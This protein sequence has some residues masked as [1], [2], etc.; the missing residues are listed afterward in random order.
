M[1]EKI[2]SLAGIGHFFN[3]SSSRMFFHRKTKS[4]VNFFVALLFLFSVTSTN[5]SSAATPEELK[6]IDQIAESIT[7]LKTEKNWLELIQQATQAI[8]QFPTVPGFFL[9]R[10]GAYKELKQFEPALADYRRVRQ[11]LPNNPLS[12]LGIAQIFLAQQQPALAEEAL[13]EGLRIAP[14]FSN[15]LHLSTLA[16]LQLGRKDLAEQRFSELKRV[17]PQLAEAVAGGLRELGLGSAAPTELISTSTYAMSL[18]QAL[19]DLR[20]GNVD[21]ARKLLGELYAVDRKILFQ[22]GGLGLD[23]DVVSAL[24]VAEVLQLNL[25][26]ATT[27]YGNF[28]LYSR[29]DDFAYS[30]YE[31]YLKT[32]GSSDSLTVRALSAAVIAHTSFGRMPLA[33]ERATQ[34]LAVAGV[35]IKPTDTALMQLALS[36]LYSQIGKKKDAQLASLK[37]QDLLKNNGDQSDDLNLVALVFLQNALF[38][39]SEFKE[40]DK[41]SEEVVIKLQQLKRT[42]TMFAVAQ[43]I[44][45]AQI[46]VSLRRGDESNKWNATAFTWLKSSENLK[47][48]PQSR[49]LAS[50]LTRMSWISQAFGN[51]AIAAEQQILAR[52][53]LNENLGS[54][55]TFTIDSEVTLVPILIKA[56]RNDEALLLSRKVIPKL[57]ALRSSL[58]LAEEDRMSVFGRVARAYRDSAFLELDGDP[59]GSFRASEQS[60]ARALLESNMVR[61][62]LTSGL[63]E[64]ADSDKLESLGRNLLALDQQV[65]S[66]RLVGGSTADFELKRQQITNEKKLLQKSFLVKYPKY[67]Q[68]TEVQISSP[69]DVA[70]QIQNNEVFISYL[71]TADNLLI[72]L[73]NKVGFRVSK[74]PVRAGMIKDLVASART[75]Y[76]GQAPAGDPAI[77]KGKQAAEQLSKL[78]FDPIK[79]EL[80]VATGLVIAPD[81][82]LAMLPFDALD[83]EGKPLVMNKDV[84]MIQSGS[85]FVLARQELKIERR[86]DLD[87]LAVGGPQYEQ[88]SDESAAPV[89]VGQPPATNAKVIKEIAPEQKS[90][91]AQSLFSFIKNTFNLAMTSVK[92]FFAIQKLEP[93]E[94]D[95]ASFV[96]GNSGDSKVVARAFAELKNRWPELPGAQ[97]EASE[98]AALF[99]EQSRTIMKGRDAS[100][101]RLQ[102]LNA[103]GQL[104]KYRYLLFSTHGYLSMFEPALSSVVLSQTNTTDDADGYVTASEWAGYRLNSEL[105]VLSAC[106]TAVGEVIQGEGITG[107][108]YAMNVAGNRRSVLSLWPVADDGTREFMVAFFTKIRAGKA[109]KT[110][111]AETKREFI[112]HKTFSAP[113]YW[114]PFVLYGG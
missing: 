80:A 74:V 95:V 98:V 57:E 33:L 113:V 60:K 62:A 94:I 17:N 55:S 72:Y 108:P 39:M 47:N 88:S 96:R 2:R 3:K 25:I 100:E 52:K 30:L 46:L 71:V 54:D 58:D 85:L 22:A 53:I 9:E 49:S 61:R 16:N 78:I 19:K 5:P 66:A 64:R 70:A 114:A 69:S 92:S 67:A 18:Q 89:A 21:A 103:S 75:Y 42:D 105:I 45:R 34:G 83:F 81:E 91:D 8:A 12:N 20:A 40:A 23:S 93:K 99:P 36:E 77:V 27:M 90:K 97:Q 50:N 32:R 84:T 38:S 107:L 109:V 56:G 26:N 87:L 43:A 104:A 24:Y 37:A 106:D 63:L 111:L 59:A 110:A 11:A 31:H 10:A 14:T 7:K 101:L 35:G 65:A 1:N 102:Q 112:A 13:A 15:L 76:S 82:S 4:L 73:I 44:S 48:R 79:S 29:A 68:L 41:I 51:Y 6:K 86:F 28:D